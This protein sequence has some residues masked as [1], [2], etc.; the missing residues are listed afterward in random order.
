MRSRLFFFSPSS[1]PKKHLNWKKKIFTE[2]FFFF[3]NSFPTFPFG[4]QE[5]YNINT[6]NHKWNGL[7]KAPFPPAWH[8]LFLNQCWTFT[9]LLSSFSFFFPLTSILSSSLNQK[10]KNHLF[11]R[12]SQDS[13]SLKIVRRAGD[14]LISWNLIFPGGS[15]ESLA[16]PKRISGLKS[17]DTVTKNTKG[18]NSP[19]VTKHLVMEK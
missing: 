11:L 14:A 16:Q 1:F 10:T 18:K 3:P 9:D 15:D 7:G 4:S 13:F 6:N 12:Y 19:A 5:K 8:S 2:K 17:G